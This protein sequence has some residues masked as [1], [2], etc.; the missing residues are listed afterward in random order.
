MSDRKGRSALERA[1]LISIALFICLVPAGVIIF[2][3]RAGIDPAYRTRAVSDITNIRIYLNEALKRE[4]ISPEGII[5]SAIPVGD[6]VP[7]FAT[8]GLKD[9]W[10]N[11]YF[12]QRLP[13]AKDELTYRLYSLGEDGV[14][15]S[16][17]VDDSR[18][19]PPD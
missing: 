11:D 17:D 5:E 16:D 12:I 8:R 19:F 7:R 14:V 18:N 10:K 6:L 1:K 3:C 9:P 13:G 15:S 4:E 2:L